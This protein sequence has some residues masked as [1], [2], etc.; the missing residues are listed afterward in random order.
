MK[1]HETIEMRGGKYSIFPSWI[2]PNKI[3]TRRKKEKIYLYD[4]N[5]DILH[6]WNLTLLLLG[7]SPRNA[8]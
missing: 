2:D 3:Y 1:P 5:S 6:T 7:P 8:V 4:E